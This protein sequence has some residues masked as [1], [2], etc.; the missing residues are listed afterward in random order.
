MIDVQQDG[1]AIT[2]NVVETIISLALKEVDDVASVGTPSANLIHQVF[3][4]NTADQG[5]EVETDDQN[6][7]LIT[8]HLNVRYGK[9]LPDIADEVRAAV[10][11]A[12]ATQLGMEVARI[13]IYIDSIRFAD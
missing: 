7:L 5:V 11:D 13:D 2:H 10:S 6:R 4:N 12:I 1:M 3:R 9:P 8:L